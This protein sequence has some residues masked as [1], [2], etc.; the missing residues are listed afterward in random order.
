MVELLG[1][2]GVRNGDGLVSGNALGGRRGRVALVA[3]ALAEQPVAA[4]RLAAMVWSDEPP[5][6]WPVALR[7]IISAIRSASAAIGLGEQRLIETTPSGYALAA[8]IDVDTRATAVSIR[9][10]E[11]LLEQERYAAALHEVGP[12]TTRE[13]AS[14][15]PGEDL[16]WLDPY[17]QSLDEQRLRALEIAAEAAAQLG[18]DFRSVSAARQM[19]TV[20]PLEE[21]AH[22]ALIRA[23]DRAGDRAAAISAYE[24]CRSLLAEQ[25]GVDPSKETVDAYLAALGRQ[26]SSSPRGR[27]PAEQSS[28]IG[29]EQEIG[30]LAAAISGPGVVCVTGKGGV[31]KS[32]LAQRVAQAAS[33]FDGGR[34]WV[35]LTAVGDDE[36][37]G[38][39][40]ALALGARIGAEDPGVT[41]TEQLAPL[42]PT[43]LVLDGTELVADGV[44]SL[45]SSLL[46]GCPALTVLAT[47]RVPLGIPGERVV[48]L[49]PLP[50]PEA[51]DHSAVLGSAAVRLLAD[52]VRDGGDV[53]TIDASTAPLLA[54]LCEQCGGLPLALELAAAQLCVMPVGDLL[55]HLSEVVAGDDRLRSVLRR[56][57]ALLDADEAAVF[58]RFA[59]LD[60]P[61]G[62]PLIK[63]VVTGEDIAAVRVIRVLRELTARGLLSVDSSGARWLYR[64]DDDVRRFARE[65]LDEAG[66]T[67][68]GFTRLADS[69]RALLPDDPR[70]APSTYEQQVTEIG[71]SVRS[72]LAAAMAGDVDRDAG[73]ELAFRLHRYWA[74]TNV[75]EGHFW[76]SRLLDGHAD[77]AWASYASY[78]A[79]YLSYWAGAVELAIAELQ[80]AAERLRGVDDS[81]RARAFIFLGGIADDLDRGAEAIEYVRQAIEAAAAYGVDLQVSAAMGMACLLGERTDPAAVAFADEAI[82]LCR[83]GG[84]AEQLAAA[85]P[86]AAMVC[87]QVGDLESARRYIDT[88]RPMHTGGRRIARVVLLSAAAGVALAE[89]DVAAAIDHGL[90]ADADATDLGVERELPLI[91]AVLAQALLAAG[92]LRGAAERGVAAFAAARSL[93]FDFPL[94]ICLETAALITLAADLPGDVAGDVAGEVAGDVADLLGVCA[95]LRERG[96][97]PALPSLRDEVHEAEARVGVR[98]RGPLDRARL[99]RATRIAVDLLERVSRVTTP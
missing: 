49:L 88:A 5:T 45:V 31:G 7:G 39:S 12:A 22:R 68:E 87:W 95:D 73:L 70:A 76:L 35:P 83:N 37:V 48:P 57:H 97:R 82:D 9:E 60:G 56:G 80:T 50:D 93:S 99:D 59:V 77:S 55:D 74:A 18:D 79:G 85:M 26:S 54:A 89:G 40:V 14:L 67:A 11:S 4:E 27:L 29:R 19:V 75:A 30:D 33:G 62:L 98:G 78:G 72:L 52:R 38:P 86:T 84:S 3:L 69:L 63:A 65:Q 51:G 53:L 92:D 66:E 64:Q 46:A 34:F 71:G 16:G 96:S 28:F 43:L 90:H 2:V 91:R 8:G 21:R 47:S 61:T 81:Y 44:A 32:R 6:T 15:L 24:R 58:R 20:A 13:G 94:A 42:G 36:L 1:P 25:L 17:R 10:A 23:L 41:L